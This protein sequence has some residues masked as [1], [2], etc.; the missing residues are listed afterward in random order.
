[1]AVLTDYLGA[2][3]RCA[4]RPTHTHTDNPWTPGSGA[5]ARRGAA[6]SVIMTYLDVT[7]FYHVPYTIFI[8][9]RSTSYPYGRTR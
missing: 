9:V 3:L 5:K 4:D 2:G 1:M 6:L 8:L 7:Y